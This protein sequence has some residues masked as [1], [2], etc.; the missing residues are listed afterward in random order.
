MAGRHA[1]AHL[2]PPE[3][4]PKFCASVY[5]F[6]ASKF[7]T[8]IWIDRGDNVGLV[9]SYVQDEVYFGQPDR[10]LP[11]FPQPSERAAVFLDAP[12]WAMQSLLAPVLIEILRSASALHGGF[13]GPCRF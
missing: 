7:H 11:V 4:D 9:R 12:P 1:E 3:P 2:D 6:Q 13:Q 8:S 10:L 5:F